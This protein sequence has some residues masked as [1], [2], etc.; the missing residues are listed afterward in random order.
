MSCQ[1]TMPLV[2]LGE[3]LPPPVPGAGLGNRD[4]LSNETSS[5]TPLLTLMREE[6]ERD[7]ECTEK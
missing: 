5:I 1:S 6:D 3:L 2:A 7:T 4:A